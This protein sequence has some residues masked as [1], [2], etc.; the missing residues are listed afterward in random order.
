[1]STKKSKFHGLFESPAET[2]ETQPSP[3]VVEPTVAV[4][5]LP[6]PAAEP[7]VIATIDQET[8]NSRKEET[9]RTRIQEPLIERKKTNYELRKDYV[10]GLKKIAADE[11]RPIY[12]IIEEALQQ[13]LTAKG[14]I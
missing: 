1:M 14:R 4:A 6:S 7:D 8:K 12:E 5:P 9:K 3:S 10:A 11:D 13:Y 2:D